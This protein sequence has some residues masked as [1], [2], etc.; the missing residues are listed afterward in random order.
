MINIRSFEIP[1]LM[2]HGLG[3]INALADEAR[4]MGMTRPLIVTDPGVVRA[5]LLDRAIAPLKA[6]NLS[7]AVFD[8]VA[9]NPPI[10]LVDEGADI[11]CR[12]ECDGLIGFGGGSSMDTAKSIGVVA[13]NGGSILDYEWANPQPIQR[14]IPPTICIP[15]TAGTGSEV[16]LW[17]V[18]TDPQRKIKFNVGG[19]PLIGA[20]KALIDPE[21]TFDLPPAITAATGMDALAHAVECYTCAY[22][23]P[24]PDAVALMAMEYV[25]QYLR[26]AF[27]QGRNTEARY[28]MSMAA[29]LGALAYGT[30][31]AGAAHAMSQ[32]A[33]GVHNVPHGALT[34]R[35]L[36]PVMEYNYLGEPHKFARIAI[37][38]GEDIRGLSVWDA[39]EKAVEAVMKLTE[40]VELPTL[41]ELGFTEEETP[42]LA[43]IAYKDPQTIG[44]PRD[45]SV[46]SYVQIYK[47]TFELGKNK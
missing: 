18:I 40:D 11:Y 26:V 44:N 13:T 32:S 9:P 5:G 7:F 38:M 3:A 21:L 24:L 47:R 4:A 28:K 35:L 29:M 33:G 19:T 12:E 42:M 39:A 15:T 27:A 37:A 16:T 30:E 43:D 2:K 6:A 31:S 8:K 23:Q 22:A 17:A 46:Q 34:G 10:A 41:Q 45:L 1:T 14:R 36:G 20:W 25:A